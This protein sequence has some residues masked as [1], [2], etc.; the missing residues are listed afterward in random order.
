[1][2]ISFAVRCFFFQM[3]VIMILAFLFGLE[4]CRHLF[5]ISPRKRLHCKVAYFGLCTIKYLKGVVL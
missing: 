2:G 4:S 3:E 5:L 1:M